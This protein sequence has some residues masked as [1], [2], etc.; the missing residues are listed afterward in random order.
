MAERSQFTGLAFYVRKSGGRGYAPRN[1]RMR[2]KATLPAAS[3]TANPQPTHGYS[4]KYWV[5]WKAWWSRCNTSP[6]K[7]NVA[8]TVTPAGQSLENGFSIT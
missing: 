3:N 5:S 7:A 1:P 2:R 6:A 4:R 8:T